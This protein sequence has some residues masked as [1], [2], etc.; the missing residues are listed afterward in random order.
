MNLLKIARGFKLAYAFQNGGQF[1]ELA[2]SSFPQTPV[3]PWRS[4]W[5][6]KS[7]LHNAFA[8]SVAKMHFTFT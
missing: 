8:N 1:L 4:N 3:R 7:K 6:I 5:S 2:V